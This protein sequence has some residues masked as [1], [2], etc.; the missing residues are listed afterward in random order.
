MI[1]IGA[2]T[3]FN[4]DSGVT[5]TCSVELGAR[6]LIGDQ[7]AILDSDFHDV[8]PAL[9]HSSH[10]KA[11]A[12]VLEDNVWLA[13][14]VMVM[15]GV[16]IGENTVVGAGSVVTKSLAANV[17]AGGVPAKTIREI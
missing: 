4:N 9:R 12:I 13:A 17:F 6:C 3:F 7:V 14:R 8:D 5:A 11:A 2:G 1:R 10:G 16:R 15:K